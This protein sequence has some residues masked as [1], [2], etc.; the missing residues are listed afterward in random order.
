MVF[1]S[2]GYQQ[3]LFSL[4]ISQEQK[5]KFTKCGVFKN[6]YTISFICLLISESYSYKAP[7]CKHLVTDK[8][9]ANI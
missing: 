8:P 7:P 6:L 3:V 1:K 2:L 4:N 9:I 5:R